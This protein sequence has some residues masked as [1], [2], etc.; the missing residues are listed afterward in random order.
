MAWADEVTDEEMAEI[1][2][3][4]L[5]DMRT[6]PKLPQYRGVTPILLG[7]LQHS[8]SAV[9]ASERIKEEEAAWTK[10]WDE[11]VKMREQ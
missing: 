7:M 2:E 6:K 4:Y 3:A 1:Y 10:R 11:Y 5:G 9:S 8:A